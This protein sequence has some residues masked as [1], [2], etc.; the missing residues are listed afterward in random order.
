MLVTGLGIAQIIS[1]GTLFYS[2]G[3]LG[4]PMREALHVPQFFL[5]GCF[6]AGLVVS[7]LLAPFSGRMVDRLGGRTVLA[8]GSVLGAIAMA[9][10]AVA[11][12]GA[13]MAAGWLVAG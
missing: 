2:I 6:T 10:L 11:A 7:A 5:F 1:W 13:V 9:L 3:V 12:N 8:A 4:A